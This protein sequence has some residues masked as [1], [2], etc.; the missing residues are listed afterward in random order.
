MKSEE[1]FHGVKRALETLFKAIPI[2]TRQDVGVR[3]MGL[4]HL[5]LIEFEVQRL[6][7]KSNGAD[8]E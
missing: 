1:H 4:L 8:E 2:A 7:R 6:E 5:G 3:D